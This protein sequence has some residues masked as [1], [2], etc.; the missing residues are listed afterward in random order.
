MF[1]PE[2]K[3]AK[4]SQSLISEFRGYNHNASIDEREFYD[5]ENMSVD[6]Y[7]AL[8]T[9]LKRQR[10]KSV[11]GTY[12]GCYSKNGLVYVVDGKVYYNNNVIFTSSYPAGTE[13]KFVSMGA[14]LIMW[15]DK[16]IY[17]TETGEMKDIDTVLTSNQSYNLIYL[18]CDENGDTF[19][20]LKSDTA[21]Q[22]VANGTYWIDTSTETSPILKRYYSSE[23]MWHE[24]TP[25]LAIRLL[26]VDIPYEQG[27]TVTISGVSTSQEDL[28]EYLNDKDF[29]ITTVKED[30][31]VIQSKMFAFYATGSS[32]VVQ[33]A[34]TSITISQIAPEMDFVCELNNRLWGCSSEKHE[35][36]CCKLGD[37]TNWASYKG[38][39]T[40]SYTA[41]IGTDGDF[42]G[43]C[44]YRGNVLFF[45]ENCIHKVY[46]SMPSN[47]QITELHEKGVQ[48]GSEKSIACVN[49]VLYYKS[50]SG[51]CAY[52]GAIPVLISQKLGNVIYKNA[53]AGAVGTKYYVSMCDHNDNYSLFVYDTNTN[54]WYR[55]DSIQVM[56]FVKVDSQ[57]LYIDKKTNREANAF[58][59]VN[60]PDVIA[61]TAEPQKT[62]K[63]FHWGVETGDIGLFSLDNKYLSKLQI[64]LEVNEG[65]LVF[66]EIKYNG[67]RE[68]TPLITLNSEIK[69][70]YTVPII[71]RRCEYF[72]LKIHGKGECKIYSISKTF[73]QGSE[74]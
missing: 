55:E 17:N 68:F 40:D 46:G 66:V 64:R 7:P 60:D 45:K 41:T 14:N 43:C 54:M 49:E 53:V 30:R 6:Y 63:D 10:Y 27:D 1:Y 58:F 13:I 36:Y 42:T 44:S 57:L 67:E 56:D 48:A 33:T 12:G 20:A 50:S 21:P 11:G 19:G 69:K 62:E 31:I 18:L 8:S 26:G 73:E 59:S 23:G 35:I 25:Y 34:Y 71:P 70:A 5:M 72:R 47:F 16:K 61:G 3:T 9:R 28:D 2:L 51:I 39:S 4:T 74:L 37:P 29:S 22:S 52:D 38:I 65:G 24:V 15:P 32:S